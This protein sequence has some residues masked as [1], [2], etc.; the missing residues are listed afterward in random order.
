MIYFITKTALSEDNVKIES[1]YFSSIDQCISV[2][3][4]NKALVPNYIV[5]SIMA[6]YDITYDNATILIVKDMD[7]KVIAD[8]II[9]GI[10][11]TKKSDEFIINTIKTIHKDKIKA[12]TNNNGNI[13]ATEISKLLDQ[14]KLE[15][16]SAYISGLTVPQ[17]INHAFFDLKNTMGLNNK[18]SSSN[19]Q[20]QN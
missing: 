13:S 7:L 3:N 19:G 17:K 4:N 8:I 1:Q 20:I 15:C 6:I 5:S 12:T 9:K 14:C 10:S 18:T 16:L 11:G 2:I